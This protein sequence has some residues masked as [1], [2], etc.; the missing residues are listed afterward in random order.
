MAT[1]AANDAPPPGTIL[2]LPSQQLVPSSSVL[3][4]QIPNV[5]PVSRQANSK[6]PHIQPAFSYFM[7]P[8]LVLPSSTS[9]TPSPTPTTTIPF[10]PLVSL[11][12]RGLEEARQEA[13]QHHSTPASNP[14]RH[15]LLNQTWCA[16]DTASQAHDP[17]FTL[18]PQAELDPYS[19]RVAHKLFIRID[20]AW[21]IEHACLTA[22]PP[23]RSSRDK[24]SEKA[25]P[26]PRFFLSEHGLRRVVA[27]YRARVG[28]SELGS[29]RGMVF[30]LNAAA[31]SLPAAEQLGMAGAKGDEEDKREGPSLEHREERAARQVD[32][33]TLE[34][35]ASKL[36]I[37]RGEER[38]CQR[39]I[40]PVC[41]QAEI[42]AGSGEERQE[43]LLLSEPDW[44]GWGDWDIV[45][46]DWAPKRRKRALWKDV[47][48]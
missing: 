13:R 19:V 28:A 26:N 14:S 38:G 30:A 4:S 7:H 11:R 2:F 43:E 33:L 3:Y 10:L 45:H 18:F 35:L 25:L 46:L 21:S 5:N 1:V 34:G 16:A 15:I 8:V 6:R 27:L 12:S 17:D 37:A 47:E 9:P 23:R 48:W 31:A 20:R 24:G 32:E 29:E 42:L 22:Y 40:A 41:K 36:G 39:D 44:D